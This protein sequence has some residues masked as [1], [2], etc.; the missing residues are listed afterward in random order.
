[1]WPIQPIGFAYW[2]IISSSAFASDGKIDTAFLLSL[3]TTC[4]R[5]YFAKMSKFMTTNHR[6][7]QNSNKIGNLEQLQ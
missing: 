2:K 3:H 7:I 5:A 6:M 1:M 4:P